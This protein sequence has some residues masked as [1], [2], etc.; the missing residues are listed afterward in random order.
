MDVRKEYSRWIML[1]D[2]Q[3]QILNMIIF[4]AD[5]HSSFWMSN[6]RQENCPLQKMI[7]NRSFSG[8]ERKIS[9]CSQFSLR[10]W[11]MEA[12]WKRHDDPGSKDAH[13]CFSF[14][15]WILKIISSFQSGATYLRIHADLI[16]A[17]SSGKWCKLHSIRK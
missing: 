13:L 8:A 2:L 5:R 4:V 3:S 12:G 1:S 11:R 9:I 10:L 16:L 17:H 6:L 15:Y 14:F 7:V